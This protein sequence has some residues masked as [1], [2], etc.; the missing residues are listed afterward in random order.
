MPDAPSRLI[1][2]QRD[3]SPGAL[4]RLMAAFEGRFVVE[5]CS[6]IDHSSDRGSY[7]AFQLAETKAHTV[8]IWA[9]G[10]EQSNVECSP[11]NEK[12]PCR[13][14]L[15]LLDQINKYTLTN[16]QKRGPLTL[17]RRGYPSE[18]P[19]PYTRIS[20]VGL[21]TLA[22]YAHWDFRP[23]AYV[24]PDSDSKAEEIREILAALSPQLAD[25][26]R[27]DIFDFLPVDQDFETS[28]ARRDLPALVAHSMMVNIDIFHHF[29]A[30][31]TPN[32][33]AADFFKKMQQRA[34]ES[35]Q[36]MGEFLQTGA[37]PDTGQVPDIPWCARVL[38][39]IVAAIRDKL[40]KSTLS[41]ATK[42]EAGNTLVHILNEVVERNRNAYSASIWEKTPQQKLPDRENNLF[43]RLIVSPMRSADGTPFVIHE[44]NF[45][46]DSIQHLVD[47]MQVIGEQMPKGGAPSNYTAKFRELLARMKRD[48][49]AKRP[50]A[51]MSREPKRAK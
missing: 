14:V 50:G 34:D 46:V 7:F 23:P 11:C 40:L 31:V 25:G 29:R 48:Q 27:P 28:M 15:W 18:V 39:N 5:F 13:H 49:P 35:L 20:K 22:E 26:Y 17:S 45:I 4:E 37:P 21:E 42:A 44:L 43:H 16:T 33:C 32:F 12:Q 38:I 3:L 36:L 30:I 41:K 24:E 47:T 19:E 10:A 51:E 9:P 8:R 2:D 1:Y 6:E